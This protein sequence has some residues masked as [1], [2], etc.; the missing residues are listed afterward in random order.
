LSFYFFLILALSEALL[1]F[2]ASSTYMDDLSDF[3]DFD[4]VSIFL[5]TKNH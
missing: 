2:G 4:E 1:S 3:G 5:L